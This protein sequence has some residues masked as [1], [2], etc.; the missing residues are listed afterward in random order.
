MATKKLC[1]RCGCEIK[2]KETG[3]WWTKFKPVKF[4]E[5]EMYSYED[6]EYKF[7]LCESCA[8]AVMEFIKRGGREG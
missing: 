4:R 6:T 1:D 5:V 8:Q 3:R 2:P 7:D